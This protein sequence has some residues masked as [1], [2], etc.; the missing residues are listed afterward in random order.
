MSPLAASFADVV[1]LIRAV[2]WPLAVLLILVLLRP[3][4]PGLLKG[5]SSRISRVSWASAS[6]E[7][8]AT[9]VRPE[10]WNTLAY[11]RDP[12]S[13]QRWADSSQT[14]FNLIKSGERADSATIDLGTGRRWLTSRLYIFAT[15]LPELLGVRC[16]VFLETRN[17]LARSFV[18]LAEPQAV[19]AALARRQGWLEGALLA[20]R[21]NL[22][23]PE[24]ESAVAE[25]RTFLSSN[26]E[27]ADELALWELI[28]PVKTLV[29]RVH[30]PL[31]E[32][33]PQV[34]ENLANAYLRSPMLSREVDAETKAEDDWV[35]LGKVPGDES[36]IRQ[37]RASWIRNGAH[38]ER[39]LRDALACPSLTD[40]GGTSLRDLQTRIV[41]SDPH[42]FI[43]VV[44]N[45]GRFKRLFNRR[46]IAERLGY[47]TAERNAG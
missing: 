7:F 18:G 27:R 9:E 34:A 3:Y 16:L 12:S 5:L 39:I 30:L 45:Q 14:L 46:E 2:A 37:E 21:L 1:A 6:V 40:P 29:G 19:R 10:V 35:T 44:D 13:T 41:L 36:K 20:E 4:L 33:N 11:L 24:T 23:R 15:L 47:E 8:V 17:R 26:A 28:G 42:D 32:T 43:A 25:F 31:A 22:A 38:L